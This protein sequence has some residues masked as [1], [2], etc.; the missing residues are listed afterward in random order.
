[1]FELFFKPSRDRP[2]Y[3]EFQVNPKSVL[4][5]AAFRSRNQPVEPFATS[6]PLGMTA[7][8][9]ID[10]TLDHPGTPTR[11]GRWRGGSPGPP[12]RRPSAG[13]SRGGLVV[14]PLPLRLLAA[15]RRPSRSPMSSAPLTRP[16]FHRF[17]DYG[18]LRFQGPPSR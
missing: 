2:E 12:S 16:S 10:G 17:E 18:R 3:F 6:P 5:E 11:N 8:A 7:V 9:V 13:P 14:R 15:R 1:M 4:F